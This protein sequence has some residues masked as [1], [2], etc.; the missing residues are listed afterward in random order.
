M[1]LL[2]FFVQKIESYFWIVLILHLMLKIW[3]DAKEVKMEAW[4][5]ADLPSINSD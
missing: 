5:K 1:F 2:M 3:E 4:Q